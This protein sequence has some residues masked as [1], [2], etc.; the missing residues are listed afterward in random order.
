MKKKVT[1]DNTFTTQAET[2][3]LKNEIE[4]HITRAAIKTLDD[5]S[6]ALAK[7]FNMTVPKVQY[8]IHPFQQFA[9]T[10]FDAVD[11]DNHLNLENK[12]TP[13]QHFLTELKNR[14]TEVK[15]LTSG[16]GWV[17]T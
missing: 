10:F 17:F 1:L 12:L 8:H 6:T 15:T 7:C 9:A 3:V 2:V 11:H 16:P 14:G 5:E 13:I 4:K